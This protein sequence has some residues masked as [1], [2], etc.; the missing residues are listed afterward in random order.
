[1]KYHLIKVCKDAI[2]SQINWYYHDYNQNPKEIWNKIILKFT[3]SN[4]YMKIP[5]KYLKIKKSEMKLTLPD[6]KTLYK[7]VITMAEAQES[8]NR[9]TY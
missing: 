9:S 5:S 2:C 4:K 7:A 1:M 6:L 8:T 3:L